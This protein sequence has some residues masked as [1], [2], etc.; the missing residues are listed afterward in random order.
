MAIEKLAN[1]TNS[2]MDRLAKTTLERFE[3][4][5]KRMDQLTSTYKNVE[6]QLGQIINTVNLETKGSYQTK[7]K[8]IQRS[9][10][11][12]IILRSGKQYDGSSNVGLK[13]E[14]KK[15][16]QE[17]LIN[18]KRKIFQIISYPKTFFNFLHFWL[19]KMYD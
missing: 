1:T 7:P 8:S 18:D 14:E 17:S 15:E 11:R 4:L 3:R 19:K 2:N 5:E 12:Q 10:A 9:I 16:K 6:V 13:R